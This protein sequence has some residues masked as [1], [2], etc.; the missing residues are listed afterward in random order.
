MLT[1]P[2]GPLAER[3]AALSWALVILGAAVFAFVVVYLVI[4]LFRAPAE[5][6]RLSEGAWIIGG[7]IVV[8]AV[9][10]VVLLAMGTGVL[11]VGDDGDGLEID[12]IGYQYWWEVRY[13]GQDA[14]TAN[15]IHIPTDTSVHLNLRSVDVIHSF[16]VPELAGKVDMVPGQTTHLTFEA[17]KAGVYRGQCAEYC[18]MQ[19]A[20]MALFVIAEEPEDFEQWVTRMSAPASEPQGA[21]ARAGK[22]IFEGAACSACHTIRGTE[23]G[24]RLGPDLTHIASRRTLAAGTI[25]NTPH[26]LREW[27]ADPQAT[28]PGSLMPA[29]PLTDDER[30]A[31]VAYLEHLE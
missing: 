30:R 11:A 19:H 18:G 29:V 2:A 6:P 7:G 26:E 22:D 1:N 15:E 9:I 21:L 14:V 28:K 31:L 4:G 10:L 3:L 24:G 23:A 12:V 17:S 13:P 16:W 25:R 27:I 8:P 5:R 20:N